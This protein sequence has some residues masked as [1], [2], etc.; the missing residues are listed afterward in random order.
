MSLYHVM[1]AYEGSID[2]DPRILYLVSR[3]VKIISFTPCRFTLGK[4]QRPPVN[5][6]LTG[7]QSLCD[8]IK[9]NNSYP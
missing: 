4:G 9:E 3:R 1:K 6:R 8:A 5:S 2:T 7:P